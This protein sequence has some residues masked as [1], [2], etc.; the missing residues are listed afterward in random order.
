L[1]GFANEGQLLLVNAASLAELQRRLPQ[2]QATQEPV[3]AAATQR[4]GH[5]GHGRDSGAPAAGSQGGSGGAAG[6]GV[7][8]AIESDFSEASAVLPPGDVEPV[9]ARAAAAAE[10]AVH[11][12]PASPAGVMRFRPN[13]LVEGPAAFAEDAWRSVRI[14]ETLLSVTGM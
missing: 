11:P 6:S 14:G 3:A 8:A 12:A 2:Q 9:P 7:S 5:T 13:L 4:P 10:A 1:P